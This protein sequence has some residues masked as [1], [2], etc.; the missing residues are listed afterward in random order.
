MVG[1]FKLNDILQMVLETMHRGMA[2]NRTLIM[3]RNNKLGTMVARFGFG[4]GINEVFRASV[5]R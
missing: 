2:F 5:F 3:I 1:E 4:T